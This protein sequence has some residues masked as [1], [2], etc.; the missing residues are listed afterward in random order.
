[1]NSLSIR[2]LTL[3]T[4][5]VGIGRWLAQALNVLFLPLALPYVLPEEFGVFSLLQIVALIGGVLMSLG[6]YNAFIAH[7]RA[8][9]G[10]S[11]NLLGRVLSQQLVFGGGIFVFLA[12]VSGRIMGWLAL[13]H[14]AIFLIVLLLGEYFA[15]LVLI[16]NRW[17]ILVNRHLQLSIIYFLRSVV[18]MTLMFIFV[19]WRHYGLLGLVMADFGAKVAA[20]LVADLMNR[21]SWRYEF[22]KADVEAV[23]RVGLPAMPDPFFFWLIIFLPLYL[24]KQN[25]LLALAGAFSLAW[26]LM[27]PVELLGNSLASAAAGKM[28]DKE[29]NHADLN[30]W[31]RLSV[32]A[33]VFTSLGILFYSPEI[34]RS[35]FDPEYYPI[36]RLLPLIAAGVMFLAY[37]YFE[38][39]SVSGS[40]KTY[41]LSLAS[42]SGVGV[43]LIGTLIGRQVVGLEVTGLFAFSFFAMW[44][45][46]RL[47]NIKQRLGHW[48][49][50][51]GSVFLT[52]LVGLFAVG[53]SP[54]LPITIFKAVFLILIAT[55]MVV[56]ELLLY[57]R[58][59]KIGEAEMKFMSIPTYAEIAK[60]I[61]GSAKILD[62]GC[63]EGFFLGEIETSGFRV[64]IDRDFERLRIGRRERPAVNFVYADA[65]SLPF[66]QNS[67]QIVVLIGVL[68]YIEKPDIV[69]SEARRVLMKFGHVEISSA[70][71]NWI[72]L[73]LNIYNWKYR[74]RFYSLA[75]LE[76]I[77]KEAGFS[78][79]S[80][81]TRGR[82]LAPLLGNL[83]IIMNLIDRVRGDNTS[84]IGPY[85]RWARKIINPIIQWEYDHHQGDGYQIFASGFRD[86]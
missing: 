59:S 1:L 41:G 13:D 81:Y 79:N 46:A 51:I 16:I 77:L 31:Y 23:F 78:V 83:F 65:S 21:R 29:T 53:F 3:K 68:P 45:V 2:N 49:Y 35:F 26:R 38:W 27:S 34:F 11:N 50:L 36:I 5:S 39:V 71:A 17:Q 28:L 76:N 25:G 67:F 4:F 40:G 10:E 54:S 58:D 9:N 47:V 72:N 84:V 20:F 30:R 66:R 22:R 63:S 15:N 37:Y 57:F 85:A 55:L 6:L 52:T 70:N 56:S 62:I 19:V 86:D 61:N 80:L 32:S 8:A 82:I 64:G 75:E 24:L 18:Q 60:R 14:S 12:L 43:M 69:F 7:F 73:Y 33:I 74:F 48:L 44:G 42:G